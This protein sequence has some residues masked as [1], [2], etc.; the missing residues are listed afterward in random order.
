MCEKCSVFNLDLFLNMTTK[1]S[2][3]EKFCAA[4]SY[5]KNKNNTK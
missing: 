2:L 1:V 3:R 5:T 4:S